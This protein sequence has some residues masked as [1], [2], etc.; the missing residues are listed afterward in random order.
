MLPY[1][2][3]VCSPKNYKASVTKFPLRQVSWYSHAPNDRLFT[4]GR[5]RLLTVMINDWSV[6]VA[7]P[8]DAS[9]IVRVRPKRKPEGETR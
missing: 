4:M 5:K 3:L 9:F 8:Q 2:T 6:W 7:H 1:R